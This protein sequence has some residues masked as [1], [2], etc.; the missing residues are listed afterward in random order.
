MKVVMF[1]ELTYLKEL[2]LEYQWPVISGNLVPLVKKRH[3]THRLFIIMA[4]I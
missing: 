4:F 1:L 2:R 3:F